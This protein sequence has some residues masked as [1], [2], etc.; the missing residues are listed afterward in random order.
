MRRR[1]H[2][3]SSVADISSANAPY[4]P[5]SIL[6]SGLI[7]LAAATSR[8]VNAVLSRRELARA[9]AELRSLDDALLKD[10]GLT[11]SEIDAVTENGRHDRLVARSTLED[12]PR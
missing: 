10:M 4:R 9:R 6:A 1:K 12:V 11:R 5:M 2:R 3:R 7:A 8:A